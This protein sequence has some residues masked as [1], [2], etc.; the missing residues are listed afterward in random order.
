MMDPFRAAGLLGVLVLGSASPFLGGCATSRSPAHQ[1]E[2]TGVFVPRKGDEIVV[3]G[4]YVHTGTPVVLWT[5]PG[6]Y[7]AYRV[8]RRFSSWDE[9]DWKTSQEKVNGLNTPNRYNLR[10]VGL[11][12]NEV[13]RLRGGGW[14]LATLQNV[15]DQFVLHFDVCGTSRQWW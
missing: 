13:E 14:D 7:D 6:G 12:T 15:V 4:H 9:A 3:A 11:S 1:P 8:E 2:A 10:Q 5:D